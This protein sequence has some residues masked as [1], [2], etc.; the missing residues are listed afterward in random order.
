M[1]AEAICVS[2]FASNSSCCGA[3]R[4]P[5]FQSPSKWLVSSTTSVLCAT[6]CLAQLVFSG[7]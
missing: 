1:R 2:G 3:C 7:R 4:S 6:V 5:R